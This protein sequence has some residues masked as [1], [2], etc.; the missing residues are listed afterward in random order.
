[1]F[2]F[3]T[4]TDTRD[5]V[6]RCQVLP[7]TLQIKQTTVESY[8]KNI[9]NKLSASSKSELINVLIRDHVL[10]QIVVSKEDK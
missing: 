7:R 8:L 3:R 2:I 6:E 1:M 4:P 10:Q 9:R 5:S